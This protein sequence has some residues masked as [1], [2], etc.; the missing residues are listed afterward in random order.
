MSLRA[1]SKT[2]LGSTVSNDSKSELL[3]LNKYFDAI[4]AESTL[5]IMAQMKRRLSGCVSVAEIVN[6]TLLIK[7]TILLSGGMIGCAGLS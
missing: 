4:A 1:L 2:L 6:M 7:S 3:Y 5:I